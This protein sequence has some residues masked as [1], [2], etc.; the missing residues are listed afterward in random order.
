MK[1][2]NIFIKCLKIKIKGGIIAHSNISLQ[3]FCT[4]LKLPTSQLQGKAKLIYNVT[5]KLTTASLRDSALAESWQSIN[6]QTERFCF[7]SLRENLKNFRGNP[8]SCIKKALQWKLYKRDSALW[9]ASLAFAMTGSQSVC[10]CV[11]ARFCV[12]GIVAIYNNAL[13]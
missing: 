1:I 12:S 6:L 2:E 8:Q 5:Q 3:N 13:L 11:I 4:S 10:Y 9:I 7:S